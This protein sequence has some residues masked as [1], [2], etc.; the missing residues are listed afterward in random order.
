MGET[1]PVSLQ[2]VRNRRSKRAPRGAR[3]LTVMLAPWALT[4]SITIAKPSPAP[5]A[6]TPLPRQKRSKMCGRSSAGMPGPLSWTL[7]GPL[8]S[9]I[10]DHFGPRCRMR[11]GILNEIAQCIGNCGSVARDHDRI[12][13]AG[14][15]DRPAD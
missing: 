4:I 2:A 14:Q 15:R 8:G 7:I 9:D 3:S 1:E 11:E 12:I 13:G 6:R 5:L 10:D